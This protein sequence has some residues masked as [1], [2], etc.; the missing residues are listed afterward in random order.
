MHSKDLKSKL[1]VPKKIN[2]DIIKNFDI[3]LAMDVMVLMALN[4]LFP[5]YMEK[6]KVYNFQNT[7]LSLRD[8]YQLR[9][10]EYIEVME[11]IYKIAIE[12]EI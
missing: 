2:L 3:I 10:D 12:L 9:D 1:H 5:K 11:N 4:K 8:P 6:F 7:S